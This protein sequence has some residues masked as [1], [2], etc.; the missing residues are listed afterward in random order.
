MTWSSTQEHILRG[1]CGV[2]NLLSALGCGFILYCFLFVRQER[3]SYFQR[4]VFYLSI[5]DFFN[6]IQWLFV[7]VIIAIDGKDVPYVCQIL[8]PYKLYLYLV[9]F[10]WTSFIATEMLYRFTHIKTTSFGEIVI[11]QHSTLKERYYHLIAWL[12]PL[13]LVIYPIIDDSMGEAAGYS[14][15]YVETRQGWSFFFLGLVVLTVL[16]IFP[17][18]TTSASLHTLVHYLLGSCVGHECGRSY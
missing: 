11:P 14:C 8:G 12:L 7:L 18:R 10:L 5:V 13:P 16:T 15:W 6:A 2:A 1:V 17:D 3:R 9:S 4:L